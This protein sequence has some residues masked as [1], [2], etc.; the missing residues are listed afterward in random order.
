MINPLK[1]TNG[2]TFTEKRA[3]NNMKKLGI[4]WKDKN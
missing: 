2:F 4:N 3:I 1:D